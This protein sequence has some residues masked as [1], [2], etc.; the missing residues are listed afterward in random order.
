MLNVLAKQQC[1]LVNKPIDGNYLSFYIILL[2]KCII[3][4]LIYIYLF[5]MY[6][7]SKKMYSLP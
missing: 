2:I 6:N 1:E 7:L 3:T 5:K 4:E